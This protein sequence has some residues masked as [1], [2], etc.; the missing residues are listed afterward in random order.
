[1]SMMDTRRYIPAVCAIAVC[2]GALASQEAVPKQMA[3]EFVTRMLE[4]DALAQVDEMKD[5]LRK[6]DRER[7]DLRQWFLDA[8]IDEQKIAKIL[9]KVARDGGTDIPQNLPE[10]AS[11]KLMMERKILA[12]LVLARIDKTMF[13]VLLKDWSHSD[14]PHIS[15]IAKRIEADAVPITAGHSIT[16]VGLP[17]EDAV[18]ILNLLAKSKSSHIRRAAV[19]NACDIVR[20]DISM[21]D[22]IL[23][24][25]TEMRIHEIEPDVRVA[26]VQNVGNLGMQNQFVISY[27]TAVAEDEKHDDKATKLAKEVL[28]FTQNIEK[29]KD[30]QGA[31]SERV[32]LRDLR[33]NQ[34]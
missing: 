14:N 2:F 20:T 6:V 9:E 7:L 19:V 8:G 10:N 13:D 1:M 25:L 4:G 26:L 12:A 28:E 5:L 27:I 34:Q 18:E 21:A 11:P 23:P 32:D 33:K 22:T 24:I 15:D 3:Q 31:P 17:A 29:L 30:P 16:L